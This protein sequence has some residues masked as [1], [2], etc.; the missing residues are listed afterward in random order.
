MRQ[1]QDFA[2]YVE[3]RGPTY[4]QCLVRRGLSWPEAQDAAAEAF[5]DL[6][7]DWDELVHVGDVDDVLFRPGEVAALLDDAEPPPRLPFSYGRVRSVLA[8]RRR[9]KW[10]IGGALTA[11]ATATLVVATLVTG[12]AQPP[13]KPD[14][15]SLG[16]AV[17]TAADNRGG[18]V[19]WA[20]G[21][22]HLATADVEVGDVRRVVAAGDAAAYEDDEGRLVAVYPDGHR[23]LLGRPTRTSPLVAS[24]SGLV[25]WVD[26]GRRGTE[27]LVVW[28]MRAEHPVSGVTVAAMSTVPTGFDGDWLTFRTGTADWVWNPRGGEPRQTGDGAPQADGDTGTTLVDTVAGSRLEQVG[29]TLRV[30]DTHTG[31][32]TYFPGFVQGALSADG[33]RVIAR[34]I[35]GAPQ[36]LDARSGDRLD[37]WYPGDWRVLDATFTVDGRV[38]WLAERD[39]HAVA[40]VCG[41]P[42]EPMDCTF[43]DDL[44]ATGTALIARDSSS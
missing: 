29:L 37:T 43:P 36:L 13:P 30:V 23:T 17:A 19:W 8:R 42:G 33:R 40:V 21:T 34:P 24:W 20:D 26:A 5:A 38:G 35:G 10:R 11:G 44:E 27:R 14:D 32:M 16:R 1:E 7:A 31:R 2:S 28:D 15:E 3:A 39:G 9:R 18:V 4:V 22:L 41:S 12:A 25:A 6:R